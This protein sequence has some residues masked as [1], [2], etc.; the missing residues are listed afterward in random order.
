VQAPRASLVRVMAEN[1]RLTGINLSEALMRDVTIK[2][3]R[4]GRAHL[5][6]NYFD[7]M[8]QHDANNH[9]P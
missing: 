5:C 8:M 2:D 1:C 4:N 9:H 7:A 3:C 6:I